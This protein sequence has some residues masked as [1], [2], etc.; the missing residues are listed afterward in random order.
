MHY[1]LAVCLH[2]SRASKVFKKMEMLKEAY[3]SDEFSSEERNNETLQSQDE[4]MHVY[5]KASVFDN[6]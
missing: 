5:C 4:E 3:D 1:V 2:N 6:V